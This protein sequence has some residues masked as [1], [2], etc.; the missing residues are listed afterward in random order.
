MIYL[1]KIISN[2]KNETAPPSIPSEPPSTDSLKNQGDLRK[3]L[4]DKASKKSIKD[5][6][7]YENTFRVIAHLLLTLQID[8]MLKKNKSKEE[9]MR[10][11]DIPE[12]Y[13]IT[14][15]RDGYAFDIDLIEI[16]RQLD[17]MK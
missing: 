11:L 16:E 15:L 9:I 2:Q 8:Q 10:V 4:I 14:Y 3:R 1:F 12:S 7:A 17:M 6:Y 5:V 13:L